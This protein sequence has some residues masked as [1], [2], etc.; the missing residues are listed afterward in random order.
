MRKPMQEGEHR[1]GKAARD[2]GEEGRAKEDE[3]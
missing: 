1:A 2:L 3:V